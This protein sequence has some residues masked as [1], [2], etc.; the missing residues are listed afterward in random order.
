MFFQ[1]FE[2]QNERVVNYGRLL[3]YDLPLDFYEKY[4]KRFGETKLDEVVENSK[5]F[6]CK[7][8]ISFLVVGDINK[9]SLEGLPFDKIVEINPKDF[10]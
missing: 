6:F 4:Y 8:R 10:F 7:E 3:A 2:T 9:N 1:N 5:K